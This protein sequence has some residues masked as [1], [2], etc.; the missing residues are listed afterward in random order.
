MYG[1]R[2][3]GS[4]V[5][6]TVVLVACGTDAPMPFQD[7]VV[8]WSDG[9]AVPVLVFDGIDTLCGGAT[10]PCGSRPPVTIV[11]SGDGH[12]A[13]ADIDRRVVVSVANGAEWTVIGGRGSGPGEFQAPT[14]LFIGDTGRLVTILD[15]ALMRVTTVSPAEGKS[16]VWGTENLGLADAAALMHDTV[17][18]MRGSRSGKDSEAVRNVIMITESGPPDTLLSVA[19]A[20]H[21]QRRNFNT[22]LVPI[23]PPFAPRPLIGASAGSVAVSTGFSDSLVLVQVAERP[24]RVVRVVLGWRP[25]EVTDSEMAAARADLDRR[26]SSLGPLSGAAAASGQG[27]SGGRHHPVVSAVVGLADGVFAVKGTSRPVADS[28]TWVLVARDGTP[29]GR[30]RLPSEFTVIGGFSSAPVL[31]TGTSRGDAVVV[32]RARLR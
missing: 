25:E 4:I 9:V 8:D 5:C 32:G 7:A 28:V 21:E 10:S 24:R 23:P 27:G 20:P 30:L 11:S 1:R 26:L 14:T 2:V 6:A 22:D 18:V 31:W 13:M 15:Q 17:V 29:A 16:R 3:R 19:V 12:L